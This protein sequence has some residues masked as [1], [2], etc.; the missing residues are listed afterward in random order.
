MTKREIALE[1]KR[2][3][4]DFGLTYFRAI[5]AGRFIAVNGTCVERKEALAGSDTTEYM[6]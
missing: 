1:G 5:R 2:I 6:A 3:G 4:M